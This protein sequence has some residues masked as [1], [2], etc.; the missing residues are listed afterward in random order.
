VKPE[1]PIA[2][3]GMPDGRMESGFDIDELRMSSVFPTRQI[4]QEYK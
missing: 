1:S 3:A 4:A 2:Q